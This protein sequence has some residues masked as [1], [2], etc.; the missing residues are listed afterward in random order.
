[1]A[2]NTLM[3]S[4]QPQYAEKIFQGIKTVELRKVKPNVVQGDTVFVYISSPIQELYGKFEVDK[5][6]SKPVEELWKIVN[7]DAG[8][9][10]KEFFDYYK[11]TN[12]GYGIYLR[13]PVIIKCPISLNDLRRVWKNFYPPQGYKYLNAAELS[14]VSSFYS[15]LYQLLL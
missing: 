11:D 7:R 6:I 13:S 5:V 1:M 12:I 4:I 3:L 14:L 9:S 8:V 2:N 15:K 10:Q